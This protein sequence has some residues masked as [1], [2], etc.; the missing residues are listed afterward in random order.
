MLFDDILMAV[1]ELKSNKMRSLLTMLGIVI[2]IA[3]VIAIMTV[4]D[5]MNTA[6]TKSMSEMGANNIDVYIVPKNSIDGEED[7]TTNTREMKE[8]DY[9]TEQMFTDIQNRYSDKL[10]G[11]SLNKTVGQADIETNA[12]K[13]SVNITGLNACALQTKKLTLK[14][15]RTFTKED[16]DNLNKTAIVSDKYIE[17]IYG[18]Q[19]PETI[20]GRQLESTIDGKY[21]SYTIIGIYEYKES[22]GDFTQMGENG[23]ITD[24]YIPLK[25]ALAQTNETYKFQDIELVAKTDVDTTALAT[26]IADYLNNTYYKENDAY[27]VYAYS[28]KKIIDQY[29]NMLGTVKLAISAIAAISLL[30]G[31]IGVMNI[32]VVSITE[33]TREIGT[34]KALGATNTSIR[35]QF[36]MESIVL[37][38]IGGIIGIIL[39]LCLGMLGSHLLHYPGVPSVKG[40]LISVLFSA[41]FGIFFGYYPA[42]KAANM[43]PIEA[44]RYE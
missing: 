34:R 24:C 41:A 25:T 31:G 37:C 7:E 17:K 13:A 32:M 40:V 22:S 35:I 33:R 10:Q 28:M 30:V 19:A 21:Y 39:G 43:N 2:G 3:S 23:L 44:L 6:M 27:K 15:G 38:I 1:S 4:G 5:S 11:I 16:F 36:I 26:E 29:T 12:K 20:I 8:K 14:A 18:K 42:N 9:I